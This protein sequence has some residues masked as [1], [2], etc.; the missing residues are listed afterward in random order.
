MTVCVCLCSRS[1]TSQQPAA[2]AYAASCICLCSQLHLPMQPVASVHAPNNKQQY[3]LLHVD[4]QQA[5]FCCSDK[6]K[7]VRNRVLRE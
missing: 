2:F 6:W 5:V 4:V 7:M 3:S 1:Y